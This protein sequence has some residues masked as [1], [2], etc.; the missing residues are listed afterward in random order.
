ASTPEGPEMS[1]DVRAR[2]G[3]LSYRRIARLAVVRALFFAMLPCVLLVADRADT[4]PSP[5]SLLAEPG[6]PV[7]AAFYYPWFPEGEHWATHYMPSLGKYDSSDSRV[8]ATHVAQARYAGLNAFISSYWG[9]GTPT[10]RRLPLLLD[11]AGRQGFHV[12]AYYE[13]ESLPS[14]PSDSLLRQ[15]FDLLYELT[16]QPAWLRVAGKPVLFVYNIG[17]EASCPAVSRLLAANQGRFYLNLK[18]FPGYRDCP[19]QPDSWHQYVPADSY[20]QQ[21]TYS[22]TV[23]PGFFK[24]D[25]L[26][27]R[28]RRDPRRFEADL[29]RQVTSAARWQLVTTFNEWGE[30]TAVEP[31]EQWQSPSG[32]GT[33]LDV[34]R[35][36]YS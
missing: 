15:D 22:A 30:G 16:A 35:S 34:M 20:D 25:E 33:Y 31:S 17:S 36:V 10:A 27:P 3:G 26:V 21:D 2:F 12:A 8:L 14:P 32:Y 18:V 23:S 9:G 28:L 11:A 24:F 7:R 13:P 19:K 5:A 4:R 6:W 1:R 29:R